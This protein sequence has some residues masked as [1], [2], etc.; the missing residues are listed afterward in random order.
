MTLATGL[1]A[2]TRDWHDMN[3]WRKRRRGLDGDRAGYDTDSISTLRRYIVGQRVGWNVIDRSRMDCADVEI[4]QA[5][6]LDTVR[7]SHRG[8]GIKRKASRCNRN[9]A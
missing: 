1:I 4:A 5:I 8:S 2:S 9:K 3:R 7:G 6:G